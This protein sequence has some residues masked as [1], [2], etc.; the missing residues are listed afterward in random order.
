MR[1]R[2]VGV[3]LASAAGLAVCPAA[4]VPGVPVGYY[5]TAAGSTWQVR[6]TS[7][8]VE[9]ADRTLAVTAVA[10]RPG[11][12]TVTIG[13]VVPG[14]PAEFVRTV[15]LSAGGAWEDENAGGLYDPPLPRVL[16]PVIPGTEWRWRGTYGP[17]GRGRPLAQTRTAAP[18]RVTVPAGTFPAVRVEITEAS[19]GLTR[20]WAEWHVLGVGAVRAEQGETVSELVAF[21]PGRD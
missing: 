18:D 15:T 3:W 1:T 16:R 17:P 14:G 2:V 21:T 20:R 10:R 19:D 9:P 8:G 6:Q 11:A 13:R 5:P 12:V 4:P 7:P